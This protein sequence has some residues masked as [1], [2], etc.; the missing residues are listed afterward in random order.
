[1]LSLPATVAAATSIYW[2]E[3]PASYPD[4]RSL[5]AAFGRFAAAARRAAGG[6]AVDVPGSGW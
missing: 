1:M 6:A 5:E 4:L 3:H 2:G